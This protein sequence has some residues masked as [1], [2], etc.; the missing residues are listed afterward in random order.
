MNQVELFWDYYQRKLCD[1]RGAASIREHLLLKNDRLAI[2]IAHR[3]AATCQEPLEDLIQLAR[4]G[5]IKAVERFNPETGNAF[6]SFAVPYIRGEILHYL[7]DAEWNG[8]K[9]PRRT[10]ELHS[11][12]K[13]LQRK[14]AASG[15]DLS[16]DE[17]AQKLKIPES[18]WRWTV[19]AVSRKPSLPLSDRLADELPTAETEAVPELSERLYE[20]LGRLPDPYRFCLLERFLGQKSQEEIAAQFATTTEQIQDWIEE[21]LFWLRGHLES[22]AVYG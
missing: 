10:V 14:L 12:V 4:I 16:L 8:A 15:R 3:C 17:V 20:Q 2:K 5:L 22:E 11:R 1:P 19:E 7:R 13:R 21:G 18:K 6:S 9:V